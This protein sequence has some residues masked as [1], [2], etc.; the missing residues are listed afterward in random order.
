MFLGLKTD[1]EDISVRFDPILERIADSESAM[2]KYPKYILGMVLAVKI[3]K[4]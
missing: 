2:S 4:F 3:Q 1:F